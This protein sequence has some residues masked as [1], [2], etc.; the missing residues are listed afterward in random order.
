M[1]VKSPK[2]ELE[3]NVAVYRAPWHLQ[4]CDQIHSC[5]LLPI[6]GH[7]REIQFPD[8]AFCYL[9]RQTLPDV[10]LF[11]VYH[12]SFP[13]AG[14]AGSTCRPSAAQTIACLVCQVK[15]NRS[16]VRTLCGVTENCGRQ[17]TNLNGARIFRIVQQPDSAAVFPLKIPDA[18]T[19]KSAQHLLRESL[20]CV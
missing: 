11:R 2:P 14:H 8:S 10:L 4:A 5:P 20:L 1:L 3:G 12:F 9:R 19:H 13:V 6:L 17:V 15:H 7:V 16:A 18:S